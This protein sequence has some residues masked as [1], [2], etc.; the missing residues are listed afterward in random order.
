MSS[1]SQ[2]GPVQGHVYFHSMDIPL[3]SVML[4][5]RRALEMLP[6]AG[7]SFLQVWPQSK[8]LPLAWKSCGL[9]VISLSCGGKSL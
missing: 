1:A 7:N 3:T 5:P 9:N 8:G 2:Q 4:K 6:D